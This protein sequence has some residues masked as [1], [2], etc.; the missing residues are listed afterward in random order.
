MQQKMVVFGKQMFECRADFGQDGQTEARLTSSRAD[1][2]L[3]EGSG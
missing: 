1:R 3:D 2:I